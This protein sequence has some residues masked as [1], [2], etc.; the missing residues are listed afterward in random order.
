MWVTIWTEECV[1][2]HTSLSVAA[3]GLFSGKT[4]PSYEAVLAIRVRQH[5][6]LYMLGCVRRR[7]RLIVFYRR[8]CRTN[9][10]YGVMS[11]RIHTIIPVVRWEVFTA[12]RS[13]NVDWVVS[14]SYIGRPY[15]SSGRSQWPHGLKR[16][17]A[18]ARLLR[19]WVRIPPGAWMSVWCECCVFSGRGLCDELITRPEESYRLWCVVVCD[20]ETSWM[21]RTWPTGGSRAKNKETLA[22]AI[23]SRP[24]S[25][26]RSLPGLCVWYCLWME[27]H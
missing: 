3:T 16:R 9:I 10:W 2:E 7:S 21:R 25:K 6:N 26:C 5:R 4:S 24:V 22:P 8:G 20:L 15:L 23:S 12:L 1:C 18:A 11:S 27:W 13:R 19:L 17:S 14:C